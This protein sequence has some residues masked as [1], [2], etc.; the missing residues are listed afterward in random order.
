M[1]AHGSLSPLGPKNLGIENKEFLVIR[2]EQLTSVLYMTYS[3]GTHSGA[4]T[5]SSSLMNTSSSHDD[6]TSVRG[7][8]AASASSPPSS[9]R[10]HIR[11]DSDSAMMGPLSAPPTPTHEQIGT[12]WMLFIPPFLVRAHLVYGPLI[13]IGVIAIRT[14]SYLAS[15]VYRTIYVT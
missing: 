10:M 12:L 15:Q 6:L 3:H 1:F 7:A 4:G 5:S 8:S 13:F 9:P 14:S 11:H 2:P